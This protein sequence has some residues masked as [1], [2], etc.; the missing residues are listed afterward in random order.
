M[1]F[2]E[3]AQTV[4]S[5]KFAGQVKAKT[6]H[7]KFPGP[8]HSTPVAALRTTLL[9]VLRLRSGKCAQHAANDVQTVITCT[10][11]SYT[12]N[13]LAQHQ[14]RSSG[15]FRRPLAP[16]CAGF[17]FDRQNRSNQIESHPKKPWCGP[18]LQGR[19]RTV[20]RAE[21][22]AEEGLVCQ[23]HQQA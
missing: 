11:I 10:T 7:F 22:C 4:S 16:S 15:R 18:R 1:N 13:S 23:T 2:A 9:V 3:G 20:T 21:T 8:G 17:A 5:F 14:L 6:C 12:S 19:P